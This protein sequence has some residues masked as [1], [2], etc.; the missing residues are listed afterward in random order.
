MAH[1]DDGTLNALLDGEVPPEEAVAVRAHLASCAECAARFEEAKRFLADAA[2]LL[3]ALAPPAQQRAPAV[4]PPAPWAGPAV[5][6]LA[7]PA[8]PGGPP[9]RVSKTAREVA[10]DIDGATHKSPAIPPNFPREGEEVPPPLLGPTGRP[11]FEGS[12]PA[13]RAGRATD[14]PTLAWAASVVL[15]LGVGYLANEVKHARQPLAPSETALAS[16]PASA[17]APSR[18]P[19]RA[20]PRTPRSGAGRERVKSGAGDVPRVTALAHKPAAAQGRKVVRPPAAEAAPL[21]DAIRPTAPAAG[22]GGAVTTAPSLTTGVTAGPPAGAPAEAR[23]EQEL[24][25]ATPSPAPTRA[26]NLATARQAPA[27]AARAPAARDRA[28]PAPPRPAFRSS[29]VDEAAAR[30]SGNLRFVEGL[31]L[32]GVKIGPGSLVPGADPARDVVRVV[33]ADPQG[34][35]LQLDQQ[36]IPLPQ[37]TGLAA[38]ERALPAALGLS[39]GDTLGTIGPGGVARLRWLD[40]SGLWISLSGNVPEDSLRALLARV[41]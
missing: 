10:I 26:G 15:A 41:R 16:A 19:T 35:R 33:Y 11:L 34:R 20:T 23:A 3:S 13:R 37:D 5:P 21:A 1:V 36:R 27:A 39:W 6:A 14:W 29:D 18:G 17:A 28:A 40:R 7:S 8:Q 22:A 31:A 38:R 4:A 25:R 2:D 12:A 32:E 30:L 24:R 9:R